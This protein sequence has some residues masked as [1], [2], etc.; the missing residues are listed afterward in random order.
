MIDLNDGY[1]SFIYAN[2]TKPADLHDQLSSSTTYVQ[3]PG[4]ARLVLSSLL[5]E[6][7]F[8]LIKIYH[9]FKTLEIR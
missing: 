6:G 5:N 9:Y 7:E 1:A 3:Y 4:A 8:L 2:E